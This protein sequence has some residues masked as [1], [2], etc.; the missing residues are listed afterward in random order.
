M[1]SNPSFHILVLVK[2]EASDGVSAGDQHLVC[3]NHRARLEGLL[4]YILSAR[5]PVTLVFNYAPFDIP[6]MQFGHGWSSRGALL[7][8]W[9]TRIPEPNGSEDFWDKWSEHK[10]E[11]D[12]T[13][14]S[15]N[16][17]H[18]PVI[19]RSPIAQRLWKLEER[20]R[21][22]RELGIDIPSLVDI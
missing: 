16:H 2:Q 20:K 9:F 18:M 6:G 14:L 19:I 12:K 22:C 1:S 21:L 13:Q 17:G 5:V 7:A 3:E 10:K 11:L 15:Q 8:D 4:T